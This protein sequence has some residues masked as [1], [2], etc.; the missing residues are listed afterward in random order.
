MSLISPSPSLAELD[1][2]ARLVFRQI[3]ENY[4]A[5]GEPV[6][7]MLIAKRN[8]GRSGLSSA[9]IRNTMA[10]LTEI[11][12]LTSPHISAGRLPTH[13]GLRLYID[14]LMET[15]PLSPSDKKGIEAQ[16]SPQTPP[17]Q[18]LEQASNALSG[19]ARGAGLV[20]APEMSGEL[21]HIEFVALEP[22]R[23]LAVLVYADGHIENRVMHVPDGLV[24]AALEQAGNY[25]SA[26]LKGKKL[27]EARQDILA[28]IEAGQ[29][30]LQ[31]TTAALVKQGVIEW[32]GDNK[33]IQKR[34]LIVRGAAR[35]LDNEDIRSD[36][37]RVRLLFEDLE[38]KEELIA[39]LDEAEQAE[40]VRIFIG[41]ENPLFSLS[42]SS[43]V[44]APYT[45]SRQ[46]IVGALGVIGPTR[47]NYARIIPMVDYTA[48]VMGRLLEMKDYVKD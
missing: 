10:M 2:R 4:L 5:T 44:V 33:S 3:V 45:D 12:L 17:E 26:R 36:L 43:L 25:L 8:Q 29:A 1:G 41:A 9:S 47:L 20:L 40:G 18:I 46:R 24:P 27:S 31:K 32:S 23:A 42:G 6:G 30:S 39:L 14:G 34:T 48:R 15:G 13:M 37:E 11:G 19:L 7:S 35:L 22:G 28:E 21:K 16:F 38:R